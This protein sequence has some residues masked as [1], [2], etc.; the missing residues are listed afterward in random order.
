MYCRFV[1]EMFLSEYVIS[2]RHLHLHAGRAN[3]VR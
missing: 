1:L 3:A 2:Y